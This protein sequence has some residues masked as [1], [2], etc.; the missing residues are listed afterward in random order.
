MVATE[1]GERHI[2]SSGPLQLVSNVWGADATCK[3]K[4]IFIGYGRDDE[5]VPGLEYA[6]RFCA[7]RALARPFMFG[8]SF[9][10]A[11]SRDDACGVWC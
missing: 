2:N 5:H 1:E 6:K 4:R 3:T 9:S 10:S 7:R 11:R 8:Q